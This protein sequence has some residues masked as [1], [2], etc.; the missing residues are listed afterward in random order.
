MGQQN[1]VHRQNPNMCPA[2]V[3]PQAKNVFVFFLTLLSVTKRKKENAK[4]NKPYVAYKS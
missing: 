3:G 1:I 2:F 4:M